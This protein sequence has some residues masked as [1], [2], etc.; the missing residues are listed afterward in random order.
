MSELDDLRKGYEEKFDAQRASHAARLAE[1]LE[2]LM[3]AFRSSLPA[4]FSGRLP[5]VQ[6]PAPAISQP[7]NALVNLS[8]S[9]RLNELDETF[10]R[11]FK[12]G[13]Y[14]NVAGLNYETRYCESLV[15][16]WEPLVGQMNYSDTAR[17]A[18]L[19]SLVR[20][21]EE[22]AKKTK[23]G[24]TFGYAL[25]GIGAYLNGW[26]FA[27]NT[28]GTPGEAFKRPEI[29]RQV[30]ATAA[31]EKLGHGFLFA[32]SAV[33]QVKVK[34][35]LAQ[36]ELSSRFGLLSSDDPTT[37][38]RR[39]QY[40][41]LHQTTQFLEEGWATWVENVMVPT[42]PRYKLNQVVEALQSLPANIPDR[43]Q[44]QETLTACL[45]VLFG[46]EDFQL[47]VIHQA[48]KVL[49][50]LNAAL[51]DHF[52]DKLGQP[53]RY[54]AGEL[55]L[56]QAEANLGAGCVPYAALIAGNISFDPAAISY[57][58]LLN[59]MNQDPRLHPDARLA[60]ISRLK[61]PTPNDIPSMVKM[62]LEIYSFS[63]PKE[64]Q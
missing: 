5:G 60:A 27:Y 20:E 23:G 36:F 52:S 63:V 19:D 6:T 1:D 15:E 62:A 59:L 56:S 12:L 13:K 37:S 18:A 3:R 22:T 55:I 57:V 43:R 17:S 8:G 35:G 24:G 9:S 54:V 38:L 61:N 53:L 28:K 44:V 2:A 41:L 32:Y 10:I 11:V 48:V 51:E 21:T 31:H 47:Q 46:E 14:Y 50:S 42:R 40:G 58:D 49:T 45:T 29:A 34:L 30:F 7:V 26:L 25:P 4:N 64:L 33:G 16:F 39:Q